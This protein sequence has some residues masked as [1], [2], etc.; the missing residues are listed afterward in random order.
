[1]QQISKEREEDVAY[2]LEVHAAILKQEEN[3]KKYILD[4]YRQKKIE[5]EAKKNAKPKKISKET[6]DRLYKTPEPSQKVQKQERPL[7]ATQTSMK[8]NSMHNT[9]RPK[10]DKEFMQKLVEMHAE[11]R[12]TEKRHLDQDKL[13]NFW[14]GMPNKVE[15]NFC[16]S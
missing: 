11:G 8:P 14:Q 12:P 6:M 3:V 10:Y 7:T 1:M 16:E 13:F 2:T 9:M 5:E 4:A 15:R